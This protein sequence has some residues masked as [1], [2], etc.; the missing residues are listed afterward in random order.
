MY[1]VIKIRTT[2]QISDELR[3]RLKLLASSRDIPY[4][5]ALEDMAEVFKAS[6]PFNSEEEFSLWFEKN[7]EKFGFK[8]IVEK[9]K[10]ESPDYKVED[11]EGNIKEVE[12]ELIG[13]DFERHKHDPSKTDIIVCVFSP[14]KKISGIP[15]L[16][17]IDTPEDPKEILD[18]YSGNYTT[19][20]IPGV[21]AEKLKKRIEG[22]GFHS[23]SS[24][25]VYI[26]RQVISN[27]EG[28]EKKEQKEAFSEEVEKRVKERLRSLGY[29]D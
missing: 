10:R 14:T 26:L 19:L 12:L 9:R 16:S 29:L 13:T 6:I 27:V 25:V 4:E 24:Y 18:K 7:L 1:G 11:G 22:T 28:N 23:L 17:I 5:D 15:V 8:K 3:K 21:L 20:S 2:I